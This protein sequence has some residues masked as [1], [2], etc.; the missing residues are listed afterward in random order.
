MRIALGEGEDERAVGEGEG[1]RGR[2]RKLL[3]QNSCG[4][5]DTMTEVTLRSLN[6]CIRLTKTFSVP[7]PFISLPFSFRVPTY[8]P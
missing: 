7:A 8:I 2:S 5:G 3:P 4:A 1:R 6:C